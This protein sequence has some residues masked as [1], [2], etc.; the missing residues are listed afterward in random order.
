PPGVIQIPDRAPG[1]TISALEPAKGSENDPITI[2][3]I[4]LQ[5]ARKVF[6]G[7]AQAT[8]TEIITDPNLDVAVKVTV[9]HIEPIPVS[10]RVAVETDCGTALS[11]VEFTVEDGIFFE[12]R[13]TLA[14][15]PRG[16]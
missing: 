2:K 16:G 9:P 1:P 13:T 4:G 6:F 10:V 3:G 14:K 11:P 8:I 15:K 12:G 5:T 7:G